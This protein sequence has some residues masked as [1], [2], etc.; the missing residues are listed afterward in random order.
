[1][2]SWQNISMFSTQIE[3][4]STLSRFL[5]KNILPF[6][7]RELVELGHTLH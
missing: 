4:F 6:S 7:V 5:K 1:M 3:H 2:K